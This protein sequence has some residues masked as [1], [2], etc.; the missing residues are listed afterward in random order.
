MAKKKETAG[1]SPK[2]KPWETVPEIDELPDS[3]LVRFD[4]KKL[5]QQIH[6]YM[7]RIRH[8]RGMAIIFLLENALKEEGLWPPESE[9]SD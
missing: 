1:S 9:D 6:K 3:V 5:L 8:Y 2:Q 4:D 7:K